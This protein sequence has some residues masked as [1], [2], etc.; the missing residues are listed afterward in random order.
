MTADVGVS[1]TEA[2]LLHA[3][4]ALARLA[5][6]RLPTRGAPTTSCWSRGSSRRRPGAAARAGAG[7]AAL[8]YPP[9]TRRRSPRD[10]TRSPCHRTDHRDPG[11]DRG[12]PVRDP[13]PRPRAERRG[14]R[15]QLPAA[16]S[17]GRGRLRR[18]LAGPVPP[19]R[20]DRRRRHR[21]LRRAFHGR[22]GGD[23]RPAEARPA[24]RPPGRLLAR[25][26]DHRRRTCAAGGRSSPATSRW[27]T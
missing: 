22:D 19:G 24:S 18:R 21:V 27:A 8:D 12:T 11:G 2:S 9:R 20:G 10:V 7:T 23:P 26:H 25:R 16:R 5:R 17:A 1:R 3:K 15:P 4:H 13:R 14:A 6:R